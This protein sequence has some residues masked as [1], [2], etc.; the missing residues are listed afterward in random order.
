MK[1]SPS[2]TSSSTVT[3]H[4]SESITD[5]NGRKLLEDIKEIISRG[6]KEVLIDLRG[7]ESLDSRGCA[8]LI[9]A[10]RAGVPTDARISIIGAQGRVEEFLEMMRLNFEPSPAPPVYSEGLLEHLGGKVIA[11]WKETREVGNLIVD[12]IYWSFLAPVGGRGIRWKGLLDEIQQMGMGAIGIV[13]LINFLLGLVIAMLSA[14]QL[15][16]FNMQ[17]LV[18]SGVVISFAREL[19]PIMTGIVVSARTGA[20]ITAQLAT[21]KVSEE[22]D[23]MRGMGLNVAKFL[24]APK[25]LAILVSLPILTMLGFLSG[26]AGGFVLGM[27][28]M[29]F[30]FDRWWWQTLQAVK[31]GDIT[32]GFLK[33]FFFAMIIVVVG[34]HNGLR[35]SGGADE[36]GRATTRSV[37]MDIFLIIVADML[38]ATLFFF[39]T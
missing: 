29:G 19:A 8:W 20:A 33:S 28:S 3:V 35:V 25:V 1:S 14:V 9:R 39:T 12:A 10:V 7:M 15:R 16:L 13:C 38:F 5:A 4:I 22:I 37:V 2:K 30:T 32:Q 11:V 17:I 6:N 31:L 36:V 21:M 26:V 34:C 27:T 23:A 18:A 24:I